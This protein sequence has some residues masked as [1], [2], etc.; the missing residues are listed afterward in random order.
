MAIPG[1]LLAIAL[2]ALM[3]ASARNVILALTIPQ[4]P[5]VVRLVRALVLSLRGQPF[6]EAMQALPQTCPVGAISW[7]KVVPT[8]NWPSGLFSSQ[9]F[10]WR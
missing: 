8:S 2:M 6:V 4:I 5:R 10:L 7:L 1:I 3:R 9:A